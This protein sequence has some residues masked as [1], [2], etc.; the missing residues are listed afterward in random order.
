MKKFK[1]SYLSD[2]SKTLFGCWKEQ[3]KGEEKDEN[4]LKKWIPLLRFL[5]TFPFLSFAFCLF[6]SVI[7]IEPEVKS[8]E[9]TCNS[10][11]RA[12]YMIAC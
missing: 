2:N 1:R 8:N 11:Y 7:Q 4:Y 3:G 12:V 10:Q 6:I 5:S 9:N